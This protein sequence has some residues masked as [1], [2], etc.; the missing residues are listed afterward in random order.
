MHNMSVSG[1]PCGN[2]WHIILNK[3]ITSWNCQSLP[4][5]VQPWG[6]KSCI[7]LLKIMF[8]NIMFVNLI[9]ILHACCML[10]STYNLK[11]TAIIYIFT[12][13]YLNN[14]WV[15]SNKVFYFLYRWKSNI[16]TKH[17]TSLTWDNQ[18]MN[19]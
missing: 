7:A 12:H 3:K 8:S 18:K 10:K 15:V 19:K 4:V 16:T 11:K 17:S 2:S 1:I 13:L 6:E 5:L 9:V 14:Q